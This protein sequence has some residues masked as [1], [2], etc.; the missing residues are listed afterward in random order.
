MCLATFFQEQG[1]AHERLCLSTPEQNGRVESKYR[2]ILNVARELR[3][4]ANLPI[5]F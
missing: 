1:I 4:Q 2:H 5:D 3:F